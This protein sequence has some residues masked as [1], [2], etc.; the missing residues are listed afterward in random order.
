MLFFGQ[1]SGQQLWLA[2]LLAFHLSPGEFFRGGDE[3]GGMFVIIVKGGGGII[4]K[5]K[6][7]R[8]S[9]SP[10]ITPTFL[11][12]ATTLATSPNFTL[13]RSAFAFPFAPPSLSFSPFPFPPS[14]LTSPPFPTTTLNPSISSALLPPALT[15]ANSDLKCPC[16]RSIAAV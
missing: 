3:G 12:R 5:Q 15:L 9:F 8:T 10:T 16:A 2:C 1:L 7:K 13:S 4:E 6:Q 11:P 14:P